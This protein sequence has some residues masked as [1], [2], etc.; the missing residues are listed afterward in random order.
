RKLDLT[1]YTFNVPDQ[2]GILQFMTYDFHK[3]LEGMLAH[4][5]LGLNGPELLRTM[6]VVEKVQ[7][8]K[9][10]ILLNDDDYKL[11]LE[12]CKKFRGFT[13]NDHVFLKRIFNCASVP[14][15]KIVKFSDNGKER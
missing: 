11:I 12:T 10:E 7:K 13:K 9:D 6:E 4:P 15:N 3:S 8:A 5:N 2:K 1:N 14:D